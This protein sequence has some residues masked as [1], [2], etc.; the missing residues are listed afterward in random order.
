[1][2]GQ[3][4]YH[5]GLAAEEA[6]ARLYCRKGLRIERKRWRGRA[7]E[8]DLVAREGAG[9]VF[10]E[11][12]KSKSFSTAAA[13]LSARQMHRIYQTAAEFLAGEPHGQNTEARF[14][15]AL[16]NGA[17]EVRILENAFGQL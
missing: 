10:I 2:N 13:S 14:D 6:V 11:V 15:V 5:A 4:N 3:I 9:V 7:G 1:M 12:K 17:G 16:V 8:I